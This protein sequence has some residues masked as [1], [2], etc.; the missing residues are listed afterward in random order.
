M[1]PTHRGNLAAVEALRRGRPRVAAA[2]ALYT[3]DIVW[4][5]GAQAGPL[6]LGQRR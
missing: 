1:N 3:D 4:E 6:V 5:A 2:L